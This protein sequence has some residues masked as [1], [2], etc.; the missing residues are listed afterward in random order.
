MALA[1]LMSIRERFTRIISVK[2]RGEIMPRIRVKKSGPLKGTLK[3][4]GAK[5][6]VLPI[7]AATILAR[8]KCTKSKRRTC[9]IRSFS[10]PGCGC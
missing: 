7:I 3:I 2:L 8:G 6:A 5:N 10:P 1:P 9:N 4:D